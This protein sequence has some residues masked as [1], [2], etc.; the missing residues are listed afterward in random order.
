MRG[1]SLLSDPKLNPQHLKW[2]YG[3][4]EMDNAWVGLVGALI[5]ACATL[6]G[7]WIAFWRDRR[8]QRRTAGMQIASQIRLWLTETTHV[9]S[10]HEVL[11]GNNPSGD[12]ND[13]NCASIPPFLFENSLAVISLLPNKIAQDVFRLIERKLSAE[14]EASFRFFVATGEEAAEQFH[15]RIA[16]I[17]V[18][19]TSLY[20]R[21]AREVGWTDAALTNDEI[22]RWRKHATISD[23]TRNQDAAFD[24]S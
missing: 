8:T 13:V 21:L 24:L 2:N 15:A 5:G 11:E 20:A 17:I 1:G 23:E 6:S 4:H 12:P 14:K 22:E 19:A 9:L 18:D 10:E 3:G 16:G 7:Q